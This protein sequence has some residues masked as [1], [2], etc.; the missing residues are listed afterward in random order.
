MPRPIRFILKSRGLRPCLLTQNVKA[1]VTIADADAASAQTDGERITGTITCGR[2]HVTA[3]QFAPQL[4]HDR[5]LFR[6]GT[7]RLTFR[8]TIACRFISKWRYSVTL[9]TP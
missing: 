1:A 3:A 7:I 5:A 8:A 2:P 6:L 4:L 9:V